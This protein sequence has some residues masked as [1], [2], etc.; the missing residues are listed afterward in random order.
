[1][2][3]PRFELAEPISVGEACGILQGNDKARV[4]AGGTD[5]LVSMKKK[6]ATA[7]LVVSLGKIQGLRTISFSDPTTLIIGPTATVAEVAESSL[8][9]TNF[10]GLAF[11]AG[12]LAS[13][14]IRNRATIG[15][16]ICTA[17]PAGDTI[18]PLIAYG[19][20]VRIAAARGERTAAVESIFKGPGQTTIGKDEIL[21]SIELKRPAGSTGASYV[22]YTIRKAM[23]IAL[24]SV[25]AVVSMDNGVCR[26]ARV[27]LG[28]VAPTFIRCPA[29][30][31]YLSGKE[32]SEDVAE[33]AGQLAVDA[34]SP[35]SDVRGSAGYR[36]RLVQVLVKRAILEA[37]ANVRT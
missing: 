36:R 37:A 19:A 3:L 2:I 18:G 24:V 4:M 8:I 23:E 25:T 15:G 16:N 5:L 11:A 26:S 31:S 14:Q 35:I 33:R 9:E 12:K 17:R 32:I 7:E 28:A 29:A 22:K 13:P 10:P 30:E 6:T 21:T 1:V 20:T 34:C 27:V